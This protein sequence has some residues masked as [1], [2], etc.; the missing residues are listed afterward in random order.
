[1]TD[2]R[3]LYR[4]TDYLR[5][6]TAEPIRFVVG[7]SLL[8]QVLQHQFYTDLPG[9]LLEALGKLFAA[10]VKVHVYPTPREVVV[11]AL[12]RPPSGSGW[13]RRARG[14]VTAD[15]LHPQ[16]PVEHLYRYL[17]EAGWVVPV[18]AGVNRV[19]LCGERSRGE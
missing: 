11:A 16:P 10:N 8:A 5:R 4:L 7:V 15:D 17:R 1:M 9:Q 18:G 13:P 3:E 14:V 2:Y 12:G 19:R 6:Y